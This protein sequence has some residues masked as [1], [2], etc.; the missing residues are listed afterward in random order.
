MTR[1]AQKLS[2]LRGLLEALSLGPM[3]RIGFPKDMHVAHSERDLYLSVRVM[4]PTYCINTS[5][6]SCA[7]SHS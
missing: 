3:S 7:E 4:T 2:N 1:S 5:F 6:F